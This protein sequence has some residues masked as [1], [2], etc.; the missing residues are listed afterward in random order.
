MLKSDLASVALLPGL[1]WPGRL[2]PAEESTPGSAPMPL[3][4]FP[5]MKMQC[6]EDYTIP[7]AAPQLGPNRPSEDGDPG[8]QVPGVAE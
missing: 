8:E 2:C 5:L 4:L 7:V 3:P 1:T 6:G